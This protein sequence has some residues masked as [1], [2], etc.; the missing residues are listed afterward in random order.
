MIASGPPS[1]SWTTRPSRAR[2]GSAATRAFSMV[3][4]WRLQGTRSEAPARPSSGSR[5]AASRP[6]T[7]AVAWYAA[8][9]RSRLGAHRRLA[10]DE[11]D[12]GRL[13]RPAVGAMVIAQPGETGWS[14]HREVRRRRALAEA[15]Q[16]LAEACLDGAQRARVQPL[17][18]A[19]H[20]AERVL[21][22]EPGVALTELRPAVGPDVAGRHAQGRVPAGTCPEPARRQDRVEQREAEG[23]HHRRGPQIALDPFQD[24]PEADQLAARVKVEQLV[25]QSRRALDR[26]EAGK[27]GGP[28]RLGADVGLDA[29]EIVGIERGLAELGAA[30]LVAADRAAVVPG[31]RSHPAGDARLVVHGPDDVIDDEGPAA[32]RA[33]GREHVADRGL[34]AR[35]AP[36]RRGKTLERGVE[37]AHVGR[38]QDDLGEHPVE[39]ARFERDG[40]ALA[41]DRGPGDPAAATEQVGHDL[42][43]SGVGVD[44]R[45]EDA[46]RW[47]RREALEDG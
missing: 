45:G 17:D 14:G 8:A 18:E 21:E 11:P 41:V 30:A 46:R 20:A 39:R 27:E 16:V 5:V 35:L 4:A 2:T 47:R 36:W 1:T 12:P 42:A 10:E 28:H 44:P 32:G 43:R 23:G 15:A 3:A 40:A 38:S 25:G 22:R 34:E 9:R 6:R 31:G 37:M 29:L 19:A 33:A 7:H 26:R 13:D 24:C